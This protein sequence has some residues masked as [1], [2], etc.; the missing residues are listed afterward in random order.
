MHASPDSSDLHASRVPGNSQ[1]LDDSLFRSRLGSIESIQQSFSTALAA[2]LSQD[3]HARIDARALPAFQ[4]PYHEF[5]LTLSSPTFLTTFAARQFR[6]QLCLEITPRLAYLLIERMLGGADA[7]PVIAK[8]PFSAIES[9]LIARIIDRIMET[10]TRAF[11]AHAPADFYAQST[12]S[13]PASTQIV[14][15][16]EWVTVMPVEV[17]AGRHCGRLTLCLPQSAIEPLAVT[18]PPDHSTTQPLSPAAPI[19]LTGLL[20]ETT[21]KLSELLTLQPGDIITTDLPATADVTLLAD[22][23]P[24]FEGQLVKFRGHRAI[25]VTRRV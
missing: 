6:G 9:R 5:R 1:T 25:A 24:L 14:P 7:E 10:L 13:N 4:L 22:N 23:Q 20:A 21:L 16:G 2:A 18:A 17:Y 19:E 12:E 3:L 15:P 11:T 8:R